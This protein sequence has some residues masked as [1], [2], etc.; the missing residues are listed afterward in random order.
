[1]TQTL[2]PAVCAVQDRI[3]LLSEIFV[4]SNRLSLIWAVPFGTGMALFASDLVH[5]VLGNQWLPA[6]PLLQIMGVVTAVHHVGYNWGA[7]VKARGTTWPIAVSAVLITAG[8]IA[9]GIPL[10]NT[11]HLVGLGI[12]FAIGEFIGFV[13]RGYWITRFFTGVG[14]IRQLGRAF[15]P[16]LVAVTP[17]L[18]GRALLGPE[19]SV[20][21]AIG[22]FA[23][24]VIMTV[25]ATWVLERPLIREASGY[26]LRP[27]LQA[28]SS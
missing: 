1:V 18:L 25:G 3:A 16:T 6:V 28:A 15:A 22:V 17:I 4:K 5:F 19:R 12:A 13:I 7:F 11:Y 26:M 9:V 14:I 2:Y 20:G 27:R 10:M 8:T 23:L 24:Y 21:G